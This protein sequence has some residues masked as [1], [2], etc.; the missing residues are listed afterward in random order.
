MS[1]AI[2]TIFYRTPAAVKP[3]PIAL[4]R[5]AVAMDPLG[6]A[7]SLGF[8]IC[9]ALA[10][11]HGGLTKSWSSPYVAGTLSGFVILVILFGVDQWL[12]RENALLVTRI[13]RQRTIAGLCAF[14]FRWVCREVRIFTWLLTPSQFEREQSDAHVQPSVVLPNHQGPVGH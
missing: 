13:L 14:I 4:G 2:V 12:W 1:L 7:L 10:T 3:V 9:F 11:Q 8:L 6:I 5:L